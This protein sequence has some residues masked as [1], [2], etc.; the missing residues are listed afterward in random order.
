MSRKS[1]F[2]LFVAS[3]FLAAT[4]P[5][6]PAPGQELQHEVVVTLKLVQVYVTD[7]E[8][9][10]VTNLGRDDF[11]LFDNGQP[12][13]ITDFESHDLLETSPL[14][15]AQL[16]ESTDLAR[17]EISARINRKFFILF[18]YEQ[19]APRGVAKS[20]K[21][22][23]QFVE[24]EMRAGDEVAVL[25][26][27]PIRGV[28]VHEY[29]QTDAGK[30]REIISKLRD[31]PARSSAEAVESTDLPGFSIGRLIGEADFQTDAQSFYDFQSLG[32]RGRENEITRIR[33]FF[34]EL[35]DLAKSLRYIPGNK[36]IIL[37]SSGIKAN[38]LFGAFEPHMETAGDEF[39]DMIR[40][41]A[42]SGC[43]VYAVH[44]SGAF[45]R[46][47]SIAERGDQSLRQ[48]SE[49]TGG[50][51]FADA[52]YAEEIATRIHQLTAHYYVLGYPVPE[53]W[54]G[55]FHELK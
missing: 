16:A 26:Y 27:S 45:D 20:K 11:I 25:S 14:A 50:R 38:L 18:D 37:F 43:P 39:E 40:E 15:E 46:M 5:P 51:Y 53:K 55:R 34:R 8:G 41:L 29:L 33:L 2:A 13:N 4:Y 12:Q 6:A 35:R 10:P 44:S 36:N 48:L 7:K 52:S 9:K 22:A 54:D 28:V 19:N 23:L 32:E 3:I 31:V 1:F 47:K 21:A 17:K 42:A 49:K 24:T 30:V